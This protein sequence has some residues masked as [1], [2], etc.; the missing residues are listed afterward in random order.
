MPPQFLYLRGQRRD[1]RVPRG[2]L[3]GRQLIPIPRRLAQP[4]VQFLQLRHPCPQPPHFIR[5]GHM[6]R[7]GHTP[8]PTTA[9]RQ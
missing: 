1:L 8:H 3:R 9:G 7:I 2:Q 5:C 4:R 6:R